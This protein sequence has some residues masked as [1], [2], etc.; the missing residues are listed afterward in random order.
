MFAGMALPTCSRSLFLVNIPSESVFWIHKA[1]GSFSTKLGATRGAK[2][3]HTTTFPK[4]SLPSPGPARSYQPTIFPPVKKLALTSW[5]PW[6]HWHAATL[7]GST[8]LSRFGQTSGSLV[9]KAPQLLPRTHGRHARGPGERAV[10]CSVH[11][12]EKSWVIAGSKK[13]EQDSETVKNSLTVWVV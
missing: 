11:G 1:L 13:N 5:E 3:N 10:W 12:C 2:C 6:S 7:L 9:R 8:K 4:E